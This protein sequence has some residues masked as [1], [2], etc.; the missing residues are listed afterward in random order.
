MSGR[1]PCRLEPLAE[2]GGLPRPP[3]NGRLAVAGVPDV[4]GLLLPPHVAIR[5]LRPLHRDGPLLGR[6]HRVAFA[7]SSETVTPRLRQ[8]HFRGSRPN[9]VRPLSLSPSD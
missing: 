6:R 2:F 9:L 8:S 5:V 4:L 7:R 3:E 1:R